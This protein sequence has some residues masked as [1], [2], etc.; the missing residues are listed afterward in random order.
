M[1]SYVGLDSSRDGGGSVIVQAAGRRPAGG[2]QALALRGIQRDL[3]IRLCESQHRQ[4]H[5]LKDYLA[6][7]CGVNRMVRDGAVISG[8]FS[9]NP[10]PPAG[11]APTSDPAPG[12]R[13]RGGGG[14]GRDVRGTRSRRLP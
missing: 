10:P 1:K 4:A 12:F 7:V 9:L 14:R 2:G 8:N 13:S 3:G 5:S 6:V 11:T